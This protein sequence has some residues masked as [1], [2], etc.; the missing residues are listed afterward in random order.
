LFPFSSHALRP[1]GQTRQRLL[2][3]VS[4][5]S[6]T[7]F[8]PHPIFRRRLITFSPFPTPPPA[9]GK[10]SPPPNE[11]VPF[12]RI[13]NEQNSYVRPSLLVSPVRIL[14]SLRAADLSGMPFFSAVFRFF[15]SPVTNLLW[16]CPEFAFFP[17]SLFT[18]SSFFPFSFHFIRFGSRPL[19]SSQPL[20][21][22]FWTTILSPPKPSA[23]LSRF[24][25]FPILSMAL[26]K[27]LSFVPPTRSLSFAVLWRR[28]LHF[29]ESP[30][31]INA[32]PARA[33]SAGFDF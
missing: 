30:F 9:R 14:L 32:S 7:C 8:F 21:P 19:G 1:Q 10:P 11:T 15:F 24:F 18:I 25:F 4:R 22:L 28:H 16:G 2:P 20:C 12:L 13:L 26:D 29:G 27:E 17:R 5:P 3:A 23:S 31:S 33:P 6:S